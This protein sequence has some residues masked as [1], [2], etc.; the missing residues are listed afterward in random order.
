MNIEQ[1]VSLA[2][3]ST[4]GLG[5]KARYLAIVES[6]EDVIE[7]LGFASLNR[8]KILMVGGGS[9]IVWRDEGYDGLILINKIRGFEVESE[10]DEGADILIGAGEDWDFVVDRTVS[11]GLSGI[12]CLSLIPGTAGATPVQNVGAYGQEIA[13]TLIS[14]DA[15]D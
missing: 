2:G 9:N 11:L 5:G 1:G 3:Y 14:V 4:M 10:N 13:E 7:C 6:K 15:H 8:L 12:E